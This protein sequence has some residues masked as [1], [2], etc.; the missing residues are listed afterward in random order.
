MPSSVREV[1]EGFF[2]RELSPISPYFVPSFVVCYSRGRVKSRCKM[3]E[4]CISPGYDGVSNSFAARQRKK[5]RWRP[6]RAWV[7]QSITR[8]VG[9]SLPLPCGQKREI[10]RRWLFSPVSDEA[11]LLA[12]RVVAFRIDFSAILLRVVHSPA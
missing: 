12:V 7:P 5:E 3:H 4:S 1:M 10:T 8:V 6:R 11:I 2:D 9:L